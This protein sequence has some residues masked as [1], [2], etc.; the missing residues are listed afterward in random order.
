[1]DLRFNPLFVSILF[2]VGNDLASFTQG[3]PKV[4][5]RCWHTQASSLSMPTP[6]VEYAK[7]MARV[8]EQYGCLLSLN[9]NNEITIFSLKGGK[10]PRL[11][12]KTL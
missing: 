10:F 9:E 2:L 1:M 6:W 11:G 5:A 12:S 8:W 7:S 3:V 4:L